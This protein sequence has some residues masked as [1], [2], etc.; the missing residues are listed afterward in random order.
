MK[1]G[2]EPFHARGV[3]CI[4]NGRLADLPEPEIREPTRDA[5]VADD[6]LDVEAM[7]RVCGDEGDGQ[8]LGAKGEVGD[9]RRR[10]AENESVRTGVQRV[11]EAC[12][13]QLLGK[14][15][16]LDGPGVALV[17]IAQ[18][19][20]HVG[21]AGRSADIEGDADLARFSFCVHGLEV[22]QIPRLL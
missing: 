17:D 12:E 11:L 6:I 13:R 16:E 18:D 21:A 19:A 9:F 3:D 7:S 5:E 10:G 20:A 15:Q 14:L 22:Y 4:Q 8:G 2:L 1:S